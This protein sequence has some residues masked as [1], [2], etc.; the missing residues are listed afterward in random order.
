MDDGLEAFLNLAPTRVRADSNVGMVSHVGPTLA[1]V[2]ELT[3]VL[4]EE[5]VEA[6]VD[7]LRLGKQ[8]DLTF[9]GRP[10]HLTDGVDLLGST[11]LREMAE[12]HGRRVE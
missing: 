5:I 7:T 10:L 12:L 4:I 8:H 11:I 1:L 6:L 3:E 9:F 2:L